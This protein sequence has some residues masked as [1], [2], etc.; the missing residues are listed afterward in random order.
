VSDRHDRDDGVTVALIGR[1]EEHATVKAFLSDVLEGPAALV[2]AGEPGIGKTVVWATC[3][4][5]VAQGFGCVLSH[6]GLEA[7]ATLSFAGLSDLLE[8][9]FDRTAAR[10]PVPRRRALEVALLLTEPGETA[11]DTRAVGLALLDVLRLLA[12]QEPLVV[13]ID[14]VQWLDGPSASVL[15]L[16]LRR[17]RTERI[18]FLATLREAP[19]V[20]VPF[21][22]ERSFPEGR[23]RELSLGP[24]TLAELH[25]LLR[26]RLGLELTRSELVRVQEAAGGN[27]FYAL[28]LGRELKRQGVK[29]DAGEPLPVPGSL[30]KLLGARLARLSTPSRDVLL[31]AATAGRPSVEL[32]AAAH[33][34]REGVLDALEAAARDGVVDVDE[35]RV[36]FAH[37]LLASV[38]YEEAPAS[39]RRAAHQALARA[40]T[41]VEERA[42]HLALAADGRDAAAARDLDAAA[43]R[44]AAR[45]ATAAAAELSELA[46]AL[47]PDELGSDAWQRRLRASR[48]LRL[49]GDAERAVEILD[50]LLV[51]STTG[52]ERSDALLGLAATFTAG[53]RTPIDLCGQALDEA[54]GDD[55]RT[56]RILAFRSWNRLLDADVSGS[57]EDAR[58][59]LENAERVGDPDLLAV[60]IQ[61]VGRAETWAGE[62][63]P[64]N[65]ERGVEIED[66]HG[67]TLES[68][69]SPRFALARWL[70][71]RGELD[72]ARA[73]VEEIDAR[74]AERGDESSRV[75]DGWILG[76]L[77]WLAGRWLVALEHTTT[78]WELAEQIQ[79]PHSRA[80][81]GR[82]KGLI[83][84]D[85]GLAEQARATIEETFN[86]NDELPRVY[87]QGLL[88]RLELTLGNLEEAG[89]LLREVPGRLLGWGLLDPTLTFWA[90]A[91]EVLVGLGELD[92]ARAVVE[93][94]GAN[95]ARLGSAWP[96]AAAAR[97]RGLLESGENELEAAQASFE[98]ALAELDR[99]SFPLEHG[100][101]LLCLGSTLRRSQQ[102]RAARDA[103]EQALTIFERLGS[104]VWSDK[105]R[106][107]LRRISGRAPQSEGLSETELRVADLAVRGRTNKEIAATLFM[108]IRTVEAHLTS[109]YRKLGIRS[110]SALAARLIGAES[111][112][113]PA[114]GVARTADAEAEP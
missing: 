23:L 47:T 45:G 27:S 114:V 86:D 110:R 18:G 54:A 34:D 35:G 70:L 10:L 81:V 59:G 107:E 22:L 87:G 77:E 95:A 92:R 105:A 11:L 72:S 78:R 25:H 103:L 40:V 9:V 48:F 98:R 62:L 7:E 66:L 8:P 65:L 63:T 93:S 2:L 46:A 51:E 3:L 71:H 49:A 12:E 29:L 61:Q 5:E 64:G 67:L 101:T 69:F 53:S 56:A 50:E 42:R 31:T 15:Q 73:I 58:A 16:A 57:L 37:P 21:E 96:I 55:R 20:A 14:D 17:L 97:C 104:P 75:H 85:L 39:K 102:K 84:I 28:E 1:N 94:Y 106:A 24:L 99:V 108:S 33:E 41:E 19:G 74:A 111:T 43:D 60:A 26:D 79:N 13:A 6:R 32:L 100:R 4:D 109:V 44:A 80:W 82:A 30:T 90:D 83:E 91:T 89:D 113:K 112:A 76:I 52:S 68:L 88:G 36:R 38:C